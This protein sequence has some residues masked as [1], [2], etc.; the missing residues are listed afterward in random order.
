MEKWEDDDYQR[1]IDEYEP[2]AILIEGKEYIINRNIYVIDSFHIELRSFS[3]GYIN[4]VAIAGVLDV[5]G[6][7]EV[8]VNLEKLPTSIKSR[9]H[10]VS[11]SEIERLVY[12]AIVDM[13]DDNNQKGGGN[14]PVPEP[15]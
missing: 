9:K 4:G 14:A 3:I 6:L 15:T 2:Y 10:I 7:G 8:A 11:K 12:K 13:I 5:R 1:I